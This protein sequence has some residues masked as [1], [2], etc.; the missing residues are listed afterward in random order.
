M[1][2]MVRTHDLPLHFHTK[3]FNIPKEPFRI[4]DAAQGPHPRTCGSFSVARAA[5]YVQ[6]FAD[7]VHDF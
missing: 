5:V 2:V 1:A 7:P 6:S 4:P 3:A